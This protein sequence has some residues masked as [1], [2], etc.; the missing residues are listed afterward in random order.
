MLNTFQSAQYVYWIDNMTV[1]YA[2]VNTI[3]TK[4]HVYTL[5]I[6]RQCVCE[7][8]IVC[9][10]KNIYKHCLKLNVL[11]NMMMVVVVFMLFLSREYFA[12]CT[13]FK[14]FSFWYS[15]HVSF[16]VN[17][18]NFQFHTDYHFILFSS[19]KVFIHACISI[20]FLITNYYHED[21]Y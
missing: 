9:K 6:H 7:C 4:S 8:T 1:S 10:R 13:L 21:C 16:F 2:L 20:L 12:I 15:E 3:D 18:E 17:M 11:A 5:S 19:I 14:D